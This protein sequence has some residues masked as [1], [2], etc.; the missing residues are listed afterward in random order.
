MPDLN[1]TGLKVKVHITA[2]LSLLV[3]LLLY[4]QALTQEDPCYG[5]GQG[6]REMT[7]AEVKAL[8]ERFIA[9]CAALPIPDPTR[10]SLASGV[11]ETYTMP[12]VAESNLS[13]ILTCLSWPSGCFTEKNSVSFPYDSLV[14][15][16]KTETKIK[17]N[18]KNK[19]P[20]ESLKDSLA[21]VEG[22]QAEIGNRIEIIAYLLP[23][24]YLDD[25]VINNPS[26]VITE[27]SDTFLLF[28]NED[29]TNLTF[30]FG[31]RTKKQA[32]TDNVD[33]PAKVL[34]PVKSIELGITGPTKAEVEV[35]KKKINRQ[36]FETLLGPVM[37]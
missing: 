15:S 37:K 33:K 16:D 26:Y 10:W 12:F 14:K 8:K 30:V 9:L 4:S 17:D 36:A 5:G 18:K 2:L 7:T 3:I 1:A 11:D 27:K 32:D 31:P 20:E 29:G 34:A 35:L 23:H 6:C 28:G 13:S 19:N 25:N 21:W 24:A 22:M